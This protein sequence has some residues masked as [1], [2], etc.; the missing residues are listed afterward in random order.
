M[1]DRIFEDGDYEVKRVT[2]ELAKAPASATESFRFLDCGSGNGKFTDNLQIRLGLPHTYVADIMPNRLKIAD[3]RG[4][5]WAY[6]DLNHKINFPDEFFDVIHAGQI[7]EHLSNTDQFI[8]EI[9][10]A[11]KPSGYVLISTPNLASWHNILYL[12]AGRQPPVAMVSDEIIL[13]K[14]A[15]GEATEPKHRRIFTPDGLQMLLK[16]H[17]FTIEATRG[18]AYY[19]FTGLPSRALARLDKAH[20]AYTVIKARKSHVIM[21]EMWLYAET[22]RS[23]AD[24]AEKTMS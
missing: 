11:L 4:W 19:P 7:I 5:K 18:A 10:R 1:I 3:L 8:R 13:H 23:K 22:R 21:D 16:W 15:D 14:L 9:Y 6:S 17:G 2:M 12:L 20:A 24:N